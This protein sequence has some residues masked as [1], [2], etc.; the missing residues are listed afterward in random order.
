[1]IKLAREA[2]GITQQEL[3]Q[4]LNVQQGTLSK[5]ENRMISFEEDYASKIADA[6]GYPINFFAQKNALY[7]YSI[8]Y[9]RRS[10]SL[11]VKIVQMIEA[12]MNIVRIHIERLLDEVASPEPNLF[13][14]DVSKQGDPELAAQFLREYWRIPKGPIKKLINLIEDH[15]IIVSSFDFGTDQVDGVSMYTKDRI[16]IICYNSNLKGDRQRLTIAH[17]LGHLIMHF[18]QV[19]IEAIDYEG[20]AFRFA[21]EFLVPEAEFVKNYNKLDLPTLANLKLYWRVSM[22]AMIY[23]AESRDLITVNQAKYLWRQ[24]SANHYNKTE[25]PNLDIPPEEPSLI[26]EIINLY[27]SELDYTQEE[28]AKLIY[29]NI[30]EFKQQYLNEYK[31]KFTVIRNKNNNPD[32]SIRKS[33]GKPSNS[34]SGLGK[35]N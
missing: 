35:S 7:P 13:Q 23:K 24:M 32:S 4:K 21:S 8:I 11:P 1:M 29:L 33:T 12:R 34:S 22:R 3:S 19:L 31:P 14:W 20:D 6:L 5:I 10:Q 15:G 28:I 26:R 27:Q 2:R 18:G 25:P 16:P 9:F 30:D 17:E